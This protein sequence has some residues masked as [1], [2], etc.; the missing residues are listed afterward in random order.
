MSIV[1]S[2][3]PVFVNDVW[4]DPIFYGSSDPNLSSFKQEVVAISSDGQTSFPNAL[5]MRP[6]EPSTVQAYLNGVKLQYGVDYVVGGPPMNRDLTYTGVPS[7]VVTDV[8][9]VWY[10]QL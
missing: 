9:E 2:A 6:L 8:F 5:S 7:L 3:K 4:D 10:A 1:P